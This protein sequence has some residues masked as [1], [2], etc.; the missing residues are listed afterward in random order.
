MDSYQRFNAIKGDKTK[1]TITKK[2]L[3]DGEIGIWKS[4]IKIL[5][6]E[7]RNKH[8]NYR[9]LHIIEDD[10]V[11]SKEFYQIIERIASNNFPF[12]ILITDMYVNPPLYKELSGEYR[13]LI[14]LGKYAI[15]T[16]LYSG[17]IASVII[18]TEKINYILNSI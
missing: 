6:T 11:I 3:S 12:D 18:P 15:T 4:W 13:K 17:C 7:S 16:D 5:E 8:K 2:N 14:K 9:Y 10:A 1:E